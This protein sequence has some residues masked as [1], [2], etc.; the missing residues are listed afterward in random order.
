MPP[1]VRPTPYS[2]TR[3]RLP[4]RIERLRWLRA[5]VHDPAG[6]VREA[7]VDELLVRVQP[8]DGGAV[9]LRVEPLDRGQRLVDEFFGR[10]YRTHPE[11]GSAVFVGR[12]A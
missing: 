3:R 11:N 2:R 12:P 9:E 8:A 7:Q 10:R 5:A 6:C 1:N 4:E